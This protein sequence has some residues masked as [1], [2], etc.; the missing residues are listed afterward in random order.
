VFTAHFCTS[1]SGHFLYAFA[2][3]QVCITGTNSAGHAYSGTF[4]IQLF[5]IAASGKQKREVT[6]TPTFHIKTIC[7]QQMTVNKAVTEAGA[8]LGRYIYILYPP[9]LPSSR[10]LYS[11]SVSFSSLQLPTLPHGVQDLPLL[12]W[13][14]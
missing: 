7:S 3:A 14:V 9:F 1:G 10:H 13:R 8:Q 5:V 11:H 4:P 2:I 6:C 12:P